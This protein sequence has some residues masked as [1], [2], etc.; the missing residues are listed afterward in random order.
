MAEAGAVLIENDASVSGG[1]RE[2][3]I[4][5][6]GRRRQVLNRSRGKEGPREDEDED[7]DADADEK[8]RYAKL[9]IDGS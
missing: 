2:T 7:E 9:Q 8:M 6:E 4:N 3:C 5:W 1:P